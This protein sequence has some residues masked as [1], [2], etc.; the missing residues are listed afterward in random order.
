MQ[1]DQPQDAPSEPWPHPQGRVMAPGQS[2]ISSCMLPQLVQLIVFC[3]QHFFFKKVNLEA[4][5]VRC[6]VVLV[7]SIL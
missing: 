1:E 7:Y 3:N 6:T 2:S 5:L 4:V